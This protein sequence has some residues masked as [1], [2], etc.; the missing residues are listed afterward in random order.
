MARDF[1]INGESLVAVK[2]PVGSLIGSIT[3]LGLTVDQI[4]ITP[5]FRHKAIN[6]DAWGEA[7]PETQFM[8]ATVGI[9]LD[10][11]HFDRTILDECLRLSMAGA[12]A[13][14]QLPRAGA[15]MGNNSPRFSA[16]NNYIGLNI[17]SPVGNKPWRFFYT[18]MT[19]PPMQFPLG[20]EKSVVTTSWVAVPFTTDPYQGGLGA[21]GQAL[22]DYVLDN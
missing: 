1:W 8:L 16:T 10:F 17:T 18:F 22:W 9:Q 4:R 2:G 19:N 13:I 6:V 5:D 11:I 21:Q 12:P 20:T 3:E 15:R 14:G 7:P